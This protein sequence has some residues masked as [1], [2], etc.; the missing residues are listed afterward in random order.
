MTKYDEY[1][2]TRT[3]EYN[4]TYVSRAIRVSNITR[5]IPPVA[6]H[7][8][9][10][11][12]AEA[13]YEKLGEWEK[14]LDTK[15]GRK[16]VTYSWTLAQFTRKG[17]LYDDPKKS[18]LRAWEI[19]TILAGWYPAGASDELKHSINQHITNGRIIPT[20][21]VLSRGKL[22][23]LY[24]GFYEDNVFAQVCL[25]GVVHGITVEERKTKERF[26]LKPGE[27]KHIAKWI[28]III[29][30]WNEFAEVPKVFEEV[31]HINVEKLRFEMNGPYQWT[32]PGALRSIISEPFESSDSESETDREGKPAQQDEDFYRHAGEL[33]LWSIYAVIK[34]YKDET[35]DIEE[36]KIMDDLERRI[37]E[38]SAKREEVETAEFVN[39]HLSLRKGRLTVQRFPRE[40]CV[41]LKGECALVDP[42]SR[43]ERTPFTRW[44]SASRKKIIDYDV[45]GS[46]TLLNV[47]ATV[48]G[49][50]I[51]KSN[52]PNAGDGLFASKPF[53]DGDLIAQWWGIRIEE[54]LS[55]RL[56]ME[57][58]S[59]FGVEGFMFT[60]GRFE[61][62]SLKED[63]GNRPAWVVPATACCAGYANDPYIYDDEGKCTSELHDEE[64]P[65][66]AK[67]DVKD[68]KVG[69]SSPRL[70]ALYA[71]GDVGQDSEILV[72]YGTKYLMRS[73]LGVNLK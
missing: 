69:K 38:L 51:A 61:E 13:E 35:I 55:K 30:R 22:G 6:E 72:P 58:T 47:D 41:F 66:N 67:F 10:W 34:Y 19:F 39:G 7:K 46:R 3:V 59:T 53:Q 27:F 71:E 45:Q 23:Q 48:Q 11:K 70:L 15:D 16:K 56:A 36:P 4:E 24:N 42:V 14:I 63:T 12:Y 9:Y 64:R 29:K 21:S 5:L 20:L 50:Y 43:L 62:Y 60:K 26:S 18:D 2:E 40:L 32:S 8:Y 52:I 49:C 54:D 25:Y 44:R 37:E 1:P 57:S 28:E 31:M 33:M 17:T 65:P 73:K 68:K